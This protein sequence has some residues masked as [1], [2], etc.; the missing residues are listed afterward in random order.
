[1]RIMVGM[2]IL[3]LTLDA[4]ADMFGSLRSR[5][6]YTEG[7]L[8]SNIRL[9]ID[10]DINI[11]DNYSAIIR[12]HYNYADADI[13]LILDEGYIDMK[14]THLYLTL[15][16]RRLLF[17]QGFSF[18][19]TDS[20]NPIKDPK[21][22]E[23][24]R[25]GKEAVIVE[26]PKELTPT[27]MLIAEKDTWWFINLYLSVFG[28]DLNMNY[29]SKDRIFGCS[30]SRYIT[31]S[32]ELHIEATKDKYLI[33]TRYTF[34]QDGM[35]VFEYF[36]NDYAQKE[37]Y[38][39]FNIRKP[40]ILRDITLKAGGLCNLEDKSFFITHSLSYLLRD[41]VVLSFRA[42]LYNGKKQS[43]FGKF[44]DEFILDA[45]VFF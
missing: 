23:E 26:L 27:F 8:T 29:A 45:E 40:N 39:F 38:L 30:L 44:D 9:N 15:G 42:N 33:G 25:E 5:F 22:P 35:G 24:V 17:G 6:I 7:S 10:A 18:N 19:P 11:D 13:E 28:A 2:C 37:E 36:N 20:I 32:V 21:E 12:S 3:F 41:D 1:M 34:L 14:F 4:N 16:K 31:E 43:K